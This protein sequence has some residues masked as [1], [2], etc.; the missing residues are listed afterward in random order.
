MIKSGL[1]LDK[2]FTYFSENDKFTFQIIKLL[3]EYFK[4][5][6]YE[7]LAMNYLHID[8]LSI[9]CDLNY[10]NQYFMILH[11]CMK[12]DIVFYEDDNKLCTIYLYDITDYLG[13]FTKK[14]IVYDKSFYLSYNNILKEINL[15]FEK[16]QKKFKLDNL[17]IDCY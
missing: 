8:V 7:M 6:F 3:Q 15:I 14:N 12:F 10:D 1:E 17:N 2:I 16:L 4:S 9:I 5:M 11:Y 13:S